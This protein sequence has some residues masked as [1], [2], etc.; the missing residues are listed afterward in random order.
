MVL[1]RNSRRD[2]KKGDKMQQ[3][4]LGPYTVV[5]SLGKGLYRIKNAT[6]KILKKAVHSAR[7][8]EY[9]TSKD[10]DGTKHCS[11]SEHRHNYAHHS[12]NRTV[13]SRT[14]FGHNHY[15]HLH[16]MVL[17]GTNRWSSPSSAT[18]SWISHLFSAS[19]N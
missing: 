18:S 4:W 11:V 15:T 17:S 8:K 5:A 10:V 6:E 7:L 2:S 9:I 16:S 3:K 14:G 12:Y 19:P 1:L 13:R